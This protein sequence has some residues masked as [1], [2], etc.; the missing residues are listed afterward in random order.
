MGF[1]PTTSALR[2]QMKR[3]TKKHRERLYALDYEGLALAWENLEKP[4]KME[5]DFRIGYP[6]V[7][8]ANCLG[9]N[10]CCARLFFWG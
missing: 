3:K 7:T 8:Q 6:N 4:G 2:T 9:V 10:N 1:E 5:I